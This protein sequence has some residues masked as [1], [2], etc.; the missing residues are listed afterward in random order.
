MFG[1]RLMYPGSLALIQAAM[2]KCIIHVAGYNV[3]VYYI[4][5]NHNFDLL[6]CIS[7]YLNTYVQY[8]SFL[9]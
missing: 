9:M 4:L 5:K 8:V 7:V 2:G 6:E 3:S 1:R